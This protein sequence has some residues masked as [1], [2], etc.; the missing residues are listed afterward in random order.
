MMHNIVERPCSSLWTL[1]WF[2]SELP[3]KD[4]SNVIGQRR[5]V[6]SVLQ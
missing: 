1:P 5:T 4:I 6:G 3:E 2:V